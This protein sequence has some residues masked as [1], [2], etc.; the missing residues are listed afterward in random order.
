MSQTMPFTADACANEASKCIGCGTCL[1]TCPVYAK[2]RNESLTARGRNANIHV[3][4]SNMCKDSDVQDIGKCLLC[5][6]CTNVCPRNIRNDHIVSIL[7]QAIIDRIGLSNGKKFVFKR[8]LYDRPFLGKVLNIAR[9]FQKFLPTRKTV[10][11][12][13]ADDLNKTIPI[14]HLPSLLPQFAKARNFPG[15]ATKFLYELVPSEM[16]TS[17]SVAKHVKVL[18]FSGCATEFLMPNSGISIVRLLNEVGMDVVFPKEQCCCGLPVHANGDHE[19]VLQMALHNLNLIEHYNAD[20]IVTGCATCGSAI[21]DMWPRLDTSHEERMRFSALATKVRDISEIVL[22]SCDFNNFS[23]HS[24]LPRGAIVTWHE[25][26]HLVGHQHVSRE[27]LTILRRVFGD[28][29]HE[30]SKQGCCGFGGSF[31][32]FNY[33]LSQKIAIEKA[34]EIRNSGAEYIITACPGCIIQLEDTLVRHNLLGKVLHLAEAV[35]FLR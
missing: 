19:T 30:L 13:I 11:T 28:S 26:C 3:L 27:P 4:L 18:Y 34:H 7:R 6:R 10:Q 35:E 5:G 16:P 22:S 21:R 9:P 31:N 20:Y 12:G 29:F 15:I 33:D 17:V 25:P 2:D 14:R 32:L 24:R 23:C 8:F 1:Q